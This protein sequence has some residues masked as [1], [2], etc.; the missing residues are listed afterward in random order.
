MQ[1]NCDIIRHILCVWSYYHVHSHTYTVNDKT[2]V[3]E[4]FHSSL[5]YII[6]NVGKT[7][8]VLLLTRMK[9]LFVYLLALN[10]K[11]G[12]EKWLSQLAENLEK[13]HYPTNCLL[14]CAQILPCPSRLAETA[15]YSQTFY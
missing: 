4:K 10:N 8:A 1:Q 5:D 7:F 9:Q 11:I 13:Q 15:C 14:C 6:H 2:N 3:G 12:W